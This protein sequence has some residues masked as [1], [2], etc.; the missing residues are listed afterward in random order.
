M[1]LANLRHAS[2]LSIF[3]FALQAMVLWDF[4]VLWWL[5]RWQQR[6]GHLVRHWFDALAEFEALAS[7]SNLAFDNPEWAF[8]EVMAD[9]MTVFRAVHGTSLARF[10]RS[11]RQR[12]RSGAG[13]HRVAG[14]RIEHVG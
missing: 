5:E 11:R 10:E 12:C 13:W 2:L 3:Y 1:R 6:C 4:H 8:A 9:T 14:D 7:F